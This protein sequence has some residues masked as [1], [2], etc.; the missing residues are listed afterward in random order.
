MR[1]PFALA[2]MALAAV[3]PSLAG[4]A[5]PGGGRPTSTPERQAA[6]ATRVPGPTPIPATWLDGLQRSAG[7]LAVDLS[8]FDPDANAVLDGRDFPAFQGLSIPLD[9]AEACS[10]PDHRDYYAG[11]PDGPFD[12]DGPPPLLVVA[13]GGGGTELTRPLLGESLGLLDITNGLQARAAEA[14]VASAPVL[15]TGAIDAADA[16]Q[17]RM[18]ELIG[19]QVAR[20]M[21]ELPC[22]RT[23]ILGHSHGGVTVTG[24]AAAL[25]ARYGDRLYAVVLDRSNALYDRPNERWPARTPVLNVY[26]S[27]Q[28]W[29]G[30]PVDLPNVINADESAAIAPRDPSEGDFTQARVNHLTLDD[31]PAVQ[32]RVVDAVMAWALGR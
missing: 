28:G 23:A 29:H 5:D 22:L 25:D 7:G 19:A 6:A 13:V 21:D 20:A 3:T 16:P 2:A 31:S 11:P 18:G 9:R 32:R 26:Q 15:T 12:C 1:A 24:V 30:V 8:C 10:R 4:C 14:G 27:N 17:T